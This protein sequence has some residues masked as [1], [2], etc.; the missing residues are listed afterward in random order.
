M[1]DKELIV[2]N[3]E[4]F[5]YGWRGATPRLFALAR[6]LGARGWRVTMLS[7]RDWGTGSQSAQE[8]AFPGSVIR[9]P[10]TG[11]YPKLLDRGPRLRRLWRGLWKVR[12]Q[13]FYAERLASG[14]ADR[15]RAW[16]EDEVPFSATPT[17]VWSVCTSSLNN[18]IAG[19]A[20]AEKVR[21]PHFV[22][23]QDPPHAPTAGLRDIVDA[24]LRAASGVVTVTEAFR[25]SVM[26]DYGIL[27]K[28]TQTAYLSFSGECRPLPKALPDGDFRILHAGTLHTGERRNARSL[29][30]GYA[31]FLA[32]CPA[33]RRDSMVELVG[34]GDGLHEAAEVAARLGI[35]GNVHTEPE[36]SPDRISERMNS[37]AVLV[38]IKYADSE[39]DVQIPGKLFKCLGA[40]RPILGVMPRR[41]EA[42]AIL[43]RSGVGIAVDNE[44]VA[45]IADAL[46][47]LYGSRADLS[48]L[49]E[50]DRD[51]VNGFSEE[52]IWQGVD[53]FLRSFLQD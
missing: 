22:E 1:A 23:F 26:V 17:C 6:Q 13:R 53:E 44:D 48:Q 49:L 38:V 46:A 31:R 36:V 43:E 21:C 12:G 19:A 34:A 51:Y 41:T 5:S 45:G 30:E 42:A 2:V 15:F 11:R 27:A 8:A 18:M 28:R 50:Q 4:G 47:R 39:H 33:A 7:A 20:L 14:W 3:A 25:R 24:V 16:I 29:V 32:G 10:F 52:R 37:A 40:G 9:T 35:L